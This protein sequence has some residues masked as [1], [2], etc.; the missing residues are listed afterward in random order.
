MPKKKRKSENKYIEYYE[1]VLL[2]FLGFEKEIYTTG[3]AN[4]Y[5]FYHYPIGKMILYTKANKIQQCKSRKWVNNADEYIIRVVL[6]EKK[7]PT[8][9]GFVSGE[10]S[11]I[12]FN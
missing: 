1:Q 7:I 12:K 10:Q 11:K 4:C 2:Q 9:I 5:A 3:R 8:Y 6:K